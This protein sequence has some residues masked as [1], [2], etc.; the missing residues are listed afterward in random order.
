MT[1]VEYDAIALSNKAE[2]ITFFISVTF[3]FKLG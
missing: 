2:D 3:T 1:E